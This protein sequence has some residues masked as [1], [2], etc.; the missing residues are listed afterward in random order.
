M[1]VEQTQ[2]RLREAKERRERFEAEQ[3]ELGREL[4]RIADNEESI[5]TEL[6]TSE[7]LEQEL[8][9]SIADLQRSLDQEK[10]EEGVQLHE[11]EKVHLALAGLEQQHAFIEENI[12]RINEETAK[13][14]SELK[15]L[16][17]NKDQA[18]E[19]IR[20]KENEIRELK[21]TIEDSAELFQE[22]GREIESQT[23]KRD[24]LNRRHKDF[25]QM[26][27]ELAKH[28]SSLDKE[29]FRLNSQKES[30]EAASGETDELYVGGI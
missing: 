30:Y 20:G 26:R 27:E 9:N 21:K 29:C 16:D 12:S 7:T 18:S 23:K 4:Q 14:E 24:E 17:E 22:I 19:E 28:I 15:K 5:Q 1:N 10:E 13:F 25:L 6:E 2:I 11:S 3:T 8:N